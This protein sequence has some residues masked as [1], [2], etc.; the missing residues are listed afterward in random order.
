MGALGGAGEVVQQQACGRGQAFKT[1][2]ADREAPGGPGVVQRRDHQAEGVG[3]GT[4][5]QVQ[6]HFESEL[7]R[8]AALVKKA[9]VEPQ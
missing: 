7:V 6:A 9:G 2:E 5:E 3:V 4:R 8:Y 1:A